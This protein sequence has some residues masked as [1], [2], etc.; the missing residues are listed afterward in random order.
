MRQGEAFISE[1]NADGIEHDIRIIEARLASQELPQVPYIPQL[2]PDIDMRR[3]EDGAIGIEDQCE[4]WPG[5]DYDEQR[6]DDEERQMMTNPGR[7]SGHEM[8]QNEESARELAGGLT[9]RETTGAF[10]H[11]AWL[12]QPPAS[13]LIASLAK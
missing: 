8:P 2:L 5:R 4:R 11:N 7:Y 12:A 1:R 6:Q 3:G 9:L 13:H 10:K